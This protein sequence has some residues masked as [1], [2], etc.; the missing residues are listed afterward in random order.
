MRADEEAIISIQD[1]M[2]HWGFYRQR[3]ASPQVYTRSIAGF[4][5]DVIF[6]RREHSILVIAYAHERRRPGY[7][8][9]RVSE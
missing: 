7:W 8:M 6:V 1:P 9:Q 3:R 2:V 5:I 4:P